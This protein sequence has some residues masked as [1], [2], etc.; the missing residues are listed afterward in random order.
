MRWHPTHSC[1]RA[2]TLAAGLCG[3]NA[4]GSGGGGGDDGAAGD[5]DD[6]DDGD[7]DDGT[8]DDADDDDDGD[9]DDADWTGDDD[10]TTGGESDPALDMPYA[11]GSRLRARVHEAEGGGRKFVGW[12]D[13][14]LD[15]DCAVV[16]IEDLGHRCVP[17]SFGSKTFAD[18]ACS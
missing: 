18:A 9:D 16:E 11:S 17:G 8:G 7:D 12:H 15:I 10:T 5:D 3:T 4:C 14:E 13:Q 2:A 6:A 1:L